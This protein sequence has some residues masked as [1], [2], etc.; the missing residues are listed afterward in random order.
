MQAIGRGC[1]RGAA[2]LPASTFLINTS[3]HTRPNRPPRVALAIATGFGLGYVPKLPG[4]AGS[5]GGV[6]L[7]LLLT[8][9]FL[10]WA[11][12][13][14]SAPDS[15][16]RFPEA[17]RLVIAWQAI[18]L[19]G[20]G[21]TGLWAA[22]AAAR[23]FGLHDPARVV[24][25]EISGQQVA[26]ALGGVGPW[27]N[28]IEALASGSLSEPSWA[29]GPN[30]KYLL[31]GFI[32]FRVFDIWKPFPA[33]RVE[34]APGGWGIMADDWVAGLYAAIGLWVARALGL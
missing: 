16:L 23:H 8:S 26:L 21:A 19:L 27:V 29:A 33:R 12:P 32:L 2:A 15:L 3:V 14:P 31:A 11:P 5:L 28:G 7:S 13:L 22:G 6:M 10:A 25:D 9:F 34:K 20:V 30:W 18:V 1:T 17:A 24:I 4:T